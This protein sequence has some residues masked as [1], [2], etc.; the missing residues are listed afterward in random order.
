MRR[1]DIVTISSEDL[2]LAKKMYKIEIEYVKVKYDY[3]ED[4]DY[5]KFLR[6]EIEQI[7]KELK[8][9]D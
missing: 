4:N 2:E 3:Q 7:D 1:C 9:R 8:E 6:G 5:I